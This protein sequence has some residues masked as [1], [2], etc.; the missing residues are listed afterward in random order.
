MLKPTEVDSGLKG[1]QV[2]YGR[3]EDAAE[4]TTGLG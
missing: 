4:G 2:L 3:R 1:F